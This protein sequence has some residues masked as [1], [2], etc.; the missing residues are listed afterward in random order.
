MKASLSQRFVAWFLFNAEKFDKE[1]YGKRKRQLFRNIKGNIL[2]IGP[3]TGVN[4][5]YYPNDIKWEGIE[6]NPK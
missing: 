5:E 3:G 4:L 6:P 1:A 2:E